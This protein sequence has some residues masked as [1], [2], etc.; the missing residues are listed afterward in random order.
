M[1][2]W[3]L[4]ACRAELSPLAELLKRG[5]IPAAHAAEILEP[6]VG[7]DQLLD[8]I[9][10]L[11]DLGHPEADVRSSVLTFLRS[12]Q[13]GI[14]FGDVPVTHEQPYDRERARVRTGLRVES[15]L[16]VAIA[17]LCD[18]IDAVLTSR[19]DEADL[20]RRHVERMRTIRSIWE[21]A[22]P[23]VATSIN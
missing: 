14:E 11:V 21:A 12:L 13:E 4:P 18:E 3:K 16:D 9:D 7:D 23:G 6:F 22:T 17:T 10:G 8:V 20:S 19:I 5:P 15:G 2:T 1:G